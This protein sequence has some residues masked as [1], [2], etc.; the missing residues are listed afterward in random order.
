MTITGKLQLTDFQSYVASGSGISDPKANHG[1]QPALVAEL[2]RIV[3]KG[4]TITVD[5]EG[6][7]D[8]AEFATDLSG[9][10]AQEPNPSG[11]RSMAQLSDRAYEL[12]RQLKARS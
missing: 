5:A 7:T 9:A 11:A 6:A 3:P 1:Y 4:G 12:A 8:L 10:L 2:A